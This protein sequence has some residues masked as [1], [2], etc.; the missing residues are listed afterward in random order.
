MVSQRR[1]RQRSADDGQHFVAVRAEF[2]A[3]LNH[4]D[5]TENHIVFRD[6]TAEVKKLHLFADT[7]IGIGTRLFSVL[8]SERTNMLHKFSRAIALLYASL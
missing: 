4:E 8:A 7:D 1:F 5:I 6:L 2:V 3:W